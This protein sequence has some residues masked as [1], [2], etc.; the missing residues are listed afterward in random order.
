MAPVFYGV[1]DYGATVAPV[2]CRVFFPSLDGSVHTAPILEGCARYPLIAFTHGHCSEAEHFKKWFEL[3]ASLARSGMVVVVPKLAGIEGGVGPF[4]DDHPDIA[5]LAAVLEWMRE[6]W[7]HSATLMPH[8]AT[9][10]VGH[11][12]G[13]LLAGRFAAEGRVAAYASLSAAWQEW[14]SV[15]PSPL[16]SITVPKLFVWGGAWDFVAT[17]GAGEWNALSRPKHKVV[18]G[19]G[20]HWDYLRAGRSTCEG[21]RGPCTLTPSVAVDFVVT[22]F[23]KYLSPELW[24]HLDTGIPESLLP[25]RF[26]RTWEQEFY[27]GSHLMSWQ[28]LVDV[29]GCDVTDTWATAR[30]E[31]SIHRG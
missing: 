28:R 8:P 2:P 30:S 9:G 20:G 13:G 5:T 10:A 15:P 31:G 16:P 23:A 14:P 3:P 19:D 11:S 6:G 18:F 26:D 25:P 29:S 21:Q 24:P 17:L 7:E 4:N 12:Y 1:R 27:A 22:F